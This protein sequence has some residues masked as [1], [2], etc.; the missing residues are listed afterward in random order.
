MKA[1]LLMGFL[2]L[3][4]V[5]CNQKDGSSGDSHKRSE[6]GHQAVESFERQHLAGEIDG[7]AWTFVS[8]KVS[9]SHEE[10]K[11]YLTLWEADVAHPCQPT[12]VGA[13]SAVAKLPIEPSRVELNEENKL[14]LSVFD[15]EMVRSKEVKEGVLKIRKVAHGQV[16]GSLLAK[17]DEKNYLEGTFTVTI[18]E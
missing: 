3:A 13:R 5:G 4:L 17:Y 2:M 8:G 1:S 14:T 15:G 12:E 10:G 18:C 6:A 11:S 16:H 9:P 7:Q